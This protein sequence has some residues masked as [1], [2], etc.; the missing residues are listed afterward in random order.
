M[1]FFFTLLS[2][3][4]IHHPFLNKPLKPDS[5]PDFSVPAIGWPGTKLISF[6]II[7]LTLFI[8]SFLT[9]PTSVIIAPGLI[10]VIIFFNI[11][12]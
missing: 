1:S 5:G 9:D 7:L 8:T 12:S 2:G 4:K 11:A 10:Y 6:G 3:V